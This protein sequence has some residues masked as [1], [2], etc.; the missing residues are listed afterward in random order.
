EHPLTYSQTFGAADLG[1]GQV[2]ASAFAQDDVRLTDRVT[3]SFGLRYEVQSIADDR[4]NVAPRLGVAW[5]LDG[6]GRRIVRS[7]AGLFFDQYYMYLTRRFAT[8]GPQ[9]PQATY[10]WSWG[11]PG[12]PVFPNAFAAAPIGK[13]AGARD[14]MIPGDRLKNP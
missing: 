13:A 9:S 1:Y 6:S 10:T 11:D 12:F 7:G 14:I 4:A 3:A 5:D 8:L 2:E